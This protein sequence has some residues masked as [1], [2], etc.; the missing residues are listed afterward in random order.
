MLVPVEGK[1]KRVGPPFLHPPCNPGM[2][3]AHIDTEAR[4]GDGWRLLHFAVMNR[5]E[6]I[7]KYLIAHIYTDME[8]KEDDGWRAL[9]LA[10][11]NGHEVEQCLRADP[12]DCW[13]LGWL[14]GSR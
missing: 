7:V 12:V 5:H 1:H 9:H 6:A 2:A 3:N 10:A 8:A 14:Q 11:R 13:R 4:A